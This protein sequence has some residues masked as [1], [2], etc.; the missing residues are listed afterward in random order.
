MDTV[1]LR[2]LALAALLT[3][4]VVVVARFIWVYPS[5]YLPRWLSPSLRRRDP[6]PP[7]QWTFLLAFVGVRGVVSLAAALAIPLTT[8]GGAPFPRRD[9]I[10][11]VTFGVIVVTLIGQGLLLPSIVRWLALPHDAE[12]ERRHEQDAEITARLE[13]LNASRDRV[14]RLSADGKVPEDVLAILRARHDH[15]AGQLPRNTKA[16]LKAAAAAAELRAD[17][18]AAERE[19]IYRLLQDGKITDEARRRIERELDLEEESLAFKRDS[20]VD[21]PL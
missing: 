1:L 15:H 11:F 16:G 17:L 8:A 14:K 19:Y 18:I 7:W 12:D 4:A 6:L 21:P 3:V 10:L 2:D 20:V 13:A 5:V 9:L